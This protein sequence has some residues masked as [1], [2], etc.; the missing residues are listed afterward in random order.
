MARVKRGTTSLKTRRN[1][2]KRVKGYQ[3][4]RSKKERQAREAIAHAGNHAF[5][6]RRKKKGDFRQLWTVK[7]NAALRPLGITYSRFIDALNK[8]NVSLNRKVLSQ[9]A[10]EQP[11]TFKRLV[12]TVK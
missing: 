12:E 9:I 3:F 7:L 6:H 10:H 1:V 11:E 4:G 8:K 2:L 5:A